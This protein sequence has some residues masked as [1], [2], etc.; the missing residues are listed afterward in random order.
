MR[1]M[2][3]C[4]LHCNQYIHR[5]ANELRGIFF[6]RLLQINIISI[7]CKTKARLIVRQWTRKRIQ[8][9]QTARLL[10]IWHYPFFSSGWLGCYFQVLLK[11]DRVDALL[12]RLLP[13]GQLLFLNHRFAF[14]LDKEIA[15]YVSK[16]KIVCFWLNH[17][18]EPFAIYSEGN[19]YAW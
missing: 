11:S 13:H 5:K 1:C 16:W 8:N 3:G 4:W 12:H 10:I 15:S 19:I 6:R 18:G 7:Y 2:L 14:S 17:I 9:R